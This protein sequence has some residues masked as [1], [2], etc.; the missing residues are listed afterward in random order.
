MV[1]GLLDLLPREE[2]ERCKHWIEAALAHD[3]GFY[4]IEDV[5]QCI[6][7]GT[8]HFWPGK[9]SAAVTQWWFFPRHKVFNMWLAGGNLGELVKDMFP[10]AAAW[11]IENGATAMSIAGRRGW[12]RVFAPLGFEPIS[13]VLVCDLAKR[14][15]L[16]L[17]QEEP[18]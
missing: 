16:L 9:R 6:S 14:G 2:W 15:A 5:E 1:S 12:E 11:A 18:A 8:A 13:T 3:G 4:A 10:V 17:N 7:E